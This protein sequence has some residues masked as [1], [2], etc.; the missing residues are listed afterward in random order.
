MPLIV[1]PANLQMTAALIQLDK[2]RQNPIPRTPT[3]QCCSTQD[4]PNDCRTPKR[5]PGL[6]LDPSPVTLPL[7]LAGK[8]H[9][10]HVD[11]LP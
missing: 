3:A 8:S 10:L 2:P 1:K 6:S 7:I 5:S 11:H 4:G 9:L